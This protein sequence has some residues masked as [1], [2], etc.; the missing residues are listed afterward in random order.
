MV[1]H[2]CHSAYEAEGRGSEVQGW[3]DMFKAHDTLEKI[4]LVELPRHAV[5]AP[6]KLLT[7]GGGGGERREG[8]EN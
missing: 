1:V 8:G 5:Y 2:I 7:K 3:G 6:T 4:I